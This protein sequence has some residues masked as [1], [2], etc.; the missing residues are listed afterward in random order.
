MSAMIPVESPMACLVVEA[1]PQAVAAV[2]VAPQCEQLGEHENHLCPVSPPVGPR[3]ALSATSI[4]GDHCGSS[5]SGRRCSRQPHY[6]HRRC[7]KGALCGVRRGVVAPPLPP[8][9][10]LAMASSRAPEG[11]LFTT[12]QFQRLSSAKASICPG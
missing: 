8:P 1:R 5:V 4:S 6:H 2:V 9:P 12:K 11:T 10:S 3:G 7:R